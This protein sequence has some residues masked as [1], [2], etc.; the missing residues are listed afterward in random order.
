[1]TAELHPQ[2]PYAPGLEAADPEL[3]AIAPSMPIARWATFV[4]MAVTAACA[5]ILAFMLRLDVAY[6]FT[7][8]A[9]RVLGDV[10]GVSP[11]ALPRN[12]YVR[13][14]GVPMVASSVRYTRAVGGG[15][16]VAFALAGQRDVWVQVPIEDGADPE[17]PFTR[18]EFDGRLV[19]MRDL[20]GRFEAVRE[21][22]AGPMHQPVDGDAF[23]LLADETPS[24]AIWAIGLVLL[25][26]GFVVVD[27]LLLL[28]WFRPLPLDQ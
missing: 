12:G 26:I 21:Y 22:L 1:M 18:S 7:S 28:R 15:Q 2:D 17:Q 14:R 23:V 24:D 19:R 11:D 3:L 13:L 10:L 5:V 8:D 4:V 6:V 16:Y 20:G 25:V 9:P 27:A